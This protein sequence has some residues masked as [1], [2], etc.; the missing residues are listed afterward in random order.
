MQERKC[1]KCGQS[2]IAGPHRIAGK[3]SVHV[4]LSAFHTATLHS[5]TCVNCGYTELYVDQKGLENIRNKGHLA[6]TPQE[7]ETA[8][9][10]VCG[11]EIVSGT[12]V[13][14]ECGNTM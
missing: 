9:C 5:F 3:Y 12:T 13:C 6:S 10:P 14:P 2:N 7:G 8:H 4:Q 11:A 1:P